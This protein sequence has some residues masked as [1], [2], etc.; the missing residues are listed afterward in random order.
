MQMGIAA[1]AIT[2]S[3]AFTAPPASTWSSTNATNQRPSIR[4]P[5]A[6]FTA[7]GVANNVSVDDHSRQAS[8]GNSVAYLREI[9]NLTAEQIARL[10]DV[11][12]RS[13][14]NWIG[15]A[16]MAAMHE[17]RLSRLTS[18]ISAVGSSPDERRQR[19]LS[20]AGGM[21][22]FHQLIAEIEDEVVLDPDAFSVRDRLHV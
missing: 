12:R 19:L 10:F 22:L 13:I 8:V 2:T 17:E 18:V 11:S 5:F 14:Q 6:D 1:A 3:I 7:I 20:S 4:V 16:P 15:G 21:S 9:S